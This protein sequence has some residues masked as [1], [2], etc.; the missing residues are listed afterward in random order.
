MRNSPNSVCLLVF[1]LLLGGC[2]ASNNSA[3]QQTST[4]DKNEILAAEAVV[5]QIERA[6]IAHNWT[7]VNAHLAS[8][9]Y[10]PAQRNAAPSMPFMEMSQKLGELNRYELLLSVGGPDYRDRRTGQ[11]YPRVTVNIRE[12]YGQPTTPPVGMEFAMLKEDGQWKL[13]GVAGYRSNR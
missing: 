7:E 1:V 3:P 8:V 12:H 10:T 6:R 4:P 9:A 13:A 2:A 11:S 5:E